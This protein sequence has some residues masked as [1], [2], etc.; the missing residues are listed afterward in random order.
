MAHKG[1]DLLLARP[2]LVAHER[3]AGHRVGVVRFP[4]LCDPT[5][6]TVIM[7]ERN[8]ALG[9]VEMRKGPCAGLQLKDVFRG[10]QGPDAGKGRI[11]IAD[12]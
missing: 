8:A 11:Q 2:L 10:I 12:D 6:P 1:G 4:V 3:I 7:I 9:A 5:D